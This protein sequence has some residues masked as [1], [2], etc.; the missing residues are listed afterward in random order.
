MTQR[1]KRDRYSP[2]A[3]PRLLLI[4]LVNLYRYTVSPLI[5]PRCRYLPTCSDYAREALA[6]HGALRGGWLALRRLLRCHPFGGSGIDSVP[7]L[8][9]E[10][11]GAREEG[12]VPGEHS[13]ERGRP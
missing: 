5:G 8:A 4:G 1:D 12:V 7:P 2:W 3:W 6:R 13:A 11:R 9:E 10:D